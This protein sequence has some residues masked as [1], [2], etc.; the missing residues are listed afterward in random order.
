MSLFFQRTHHL[1]SVS[2]I[3]INKAKYKLGKTVEELICEVKVIFNVR[4]VLF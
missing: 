2:L 3:H 4:Q 1:T